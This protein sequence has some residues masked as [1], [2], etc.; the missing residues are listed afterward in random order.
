VGSTLLII[1]KIGPFYIITIFSILR[2]KNIYIKTEISLSFSFR[3]RH[4]FA[5]ARFGPFAPASCAR[6]TI[7]PLN[8][9]LLTN[10]GGNKIHDSNRSLH[11]PKKKKNDRL[12][13]GCSWSQR[14]GRRENIFFFGMRN[15]Y[16]KYEITKG[17][18]CSPVSC[19]GRDTRAKCLTFL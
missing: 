2:Q 7:I 11:R 5:F 8:S 15:H 18:M 3:G 17:S 14:G 4:A 10:V 1:I 16:S 19:R 6:L 13:L 9:Q 12:A